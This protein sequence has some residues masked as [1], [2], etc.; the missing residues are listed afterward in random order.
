VGEVLP[1]DRSDA[2][3]RAAVG[4]YVHA[5]GTCAL[6]T[7][8][9]T[10]CRVRGYEGLMVCDASV[11]PVLPRANTHLPTVAVAER[12][13]AMTAARLLEVA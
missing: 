7:V 1:Y 3:V 4:D 13:A 2:G 10:E 5:G 6:G 12:V 9:D 8:V 11:L